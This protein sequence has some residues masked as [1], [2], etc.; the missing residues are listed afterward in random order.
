MSILI[1]DDS[2]DARALLATLLRALGHD[3]VAEAASGPGAL[4]FLEAADAGG[5]AAPD[6]ILMDIL[7]PGAD[8][9]ET[10]RRLASDAR[11][12]DIPI[13]IVSAMADVNSLEQALE[14]GAADYLLKPVNRV[15]LRARVRS[16]LRLKRETERRK[17]LERELAR[18]K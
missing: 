6:L 18:L 12:T 2:K 17:T 3:D 13:L 5:H 16:A 1:V 15:E 4:R 7:M 14:A 8:G 9:I 10:T 11:F